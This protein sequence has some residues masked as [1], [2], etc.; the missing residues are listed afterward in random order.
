M[1]NPKSVCVITNFRTGSTSFTLLKAEE[2]NLPYKA[3]MFSHDR[4]YGLGK[5]KAKWEVAS[6][7]HEYTEEEKRFRIS[8]DLFLDQIAVGE[9]CCFKVMPNQVKEEGN[10]DKLLQTV[11]KIYYLY[12]RDFKAQAKSW[13][14]VRRIGDFGGT[15]FISMEKRKNTEKMKELH[16]GILGKE[17]TV[18]HH[19]DLTDES[20]VNWS[21]KSGF[22]IAGLI[23]NYRDMA[24]LYRQYPGELICME[25]YFAERDY[26]RYN[27]EI[28]W[29]VEP[30]WP[31]P[32][33]NPENLFKSIDKT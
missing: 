17:Q 29:E 32:D 6:K 31:E 12:R 7:M 14:A 26:P 18:K 19:I 1:S 4:P 24:N 23:K 8:E 11:D 16:L 13:I 3:E 2:Y 21:V 30:N 5:A 10:M 25:D 20:T 28:T 9:P 33:F 22:L 27:R 15:G